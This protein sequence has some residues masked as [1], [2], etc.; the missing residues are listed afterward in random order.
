[1]DASTDRYTL[2]PPFTHRAGLAWVANLPDDAWPYDSSDDAVRSR[3][4]LWENGIQLGPRHAAHLEI[5]NEGGGR[6]S[7]WRGG[8]IFSTRDGSDPNVNGCGYAVSLGEPTLTTVGFGSCHLHDALSD[9]EERKLAHRTWQTPLLVYTPREAAQLVAFYAGEQDIPA[10][11]RMFTVTGGEDTAPGQRPAELA[12]LEFGSFIDVSYDAFFL[13]RCQLHT[14][15]MNPIAALGREA[16]SR[17]RTLVQSGPVAANEAV[18][19]ESV[20]QILELVPMTDLDPVLAGD[21]VREARGSE[22]DV[23]AAADTVRYICDTLQ[24]SATCV[25]GTQNA[26]T[27]DGRPLNWPGNFPKVLEAVCG[28]VGLPLLHTGQ[29]AA[30]RG[31]A[32]AIKEDLFHFTPQ[33][34][35]VMA[36]EMLAMGRRALHEQASGL[37]TSA[38]RSGGMEPALAMQ[39]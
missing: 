15:L 36:D 7:H 31:G 18:R 28:E 22:Q 30:E 33:M 35:S 32:F 5:E 34:I 38:A 39:P 6:Y 9:L 11:L 19:S 12:F 26:F 2:R 29:L 21:I 27:P 10:C 13:T 1:M 23:A 14:L 16:N 8:L 17:R 3:L 20:E 24:A 25:L 37:P 4:E